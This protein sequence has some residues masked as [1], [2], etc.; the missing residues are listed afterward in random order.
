MPKPKPIPPDAFVD[1]DLYRLG[2]QRIA[3]AVPVSQL[4]TLLARHIGEIGR[5]IL[6]RVL[7]DSGRPVLVRWEYAQ[8]G[9][10]P[11]YVRV[12]ENVTE[13]EISM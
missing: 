13:T 2:W 8:A 11:V 7:A 3:Q 4:A 9:V 1:V 6:A 5:D 10:V 12:V